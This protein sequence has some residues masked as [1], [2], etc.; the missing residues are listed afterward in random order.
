[1]KESKTEVS[2][3][4]ERPWVGHMRLDLPFNSTSNPFDDSTPDDHMDQ[5]DILRLR[6]G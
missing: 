4:N 1:M 5:G 2:S 6:K 3:T